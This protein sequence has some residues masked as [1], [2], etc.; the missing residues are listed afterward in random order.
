M[1]DARYAELLNK[2]NNYVSSNSVDVSP[3]QKVSGV[4]DEST[5]D[6]LFLSKDM[7]MERLSYKEKILAHVLLHNFFSR[8]GIKNLNKETIIDLHKKVSCLIPHSRF[9]MLDEK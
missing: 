5:S 1:N 9:D 7:N 3:T 2:L 4:D 6:T 8:G